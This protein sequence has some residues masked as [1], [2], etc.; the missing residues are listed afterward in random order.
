MTGFKDWLE[1]VA[2]L[3]KVGG[4]SIDTD[5]PDKDRGGGD[6]DDWD[7]ENL[8]AKY[9]LQAARWAKESQ[10]A[11]QIR[12]EAMSLLTST[13]PRAKSLIWP[14]VSV[15][16]DRK[17]IIKEKK[18]RAIVYVSWK[19]RPFSRLWDQM[20]LA[21]QPIMLKSDLYRIFGDEGRE[22]SSVLTFKGDVAEFVF[23][24]CLQQ[25]PHP[26]TKLLMMAENILGREKVESYIKRK[27]AAYARWP[28]FQDVKLV[29][30]EETGKIMGHGME[31]FEFAFDR[32]YTFSI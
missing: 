32:R 11:G 25:A 8:I 15:R 31:Y 6:S 4:G 16:N 21:C 28:H 22:G 29:A 26:Q 24:E 17:H 14:L 7:F 20:V 18:G 3:P 2:M 12:F 5:P 23:Y 30:T 27:I 13:K 10:F 19:V 9:N 1:V